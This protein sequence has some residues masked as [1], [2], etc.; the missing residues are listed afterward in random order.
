ASGAAR[1]VTCSVMMLARPSWVSRWPSRAAAEANIPGPRTRTRVRESAVG[2]LNCWFVTAAICAGW[3]AARAT[4]GWAA[5]ALAGWAAMTIVGCAAAGAAGAA[6]GAA[7]ATGRKRFEA[8]A[9]AGAAAIACCG[10]YITGACAGA[11][12]ICGACGWITKLG[13]GTET[14][15]AIVVAIA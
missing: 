7:L 10:T 11:M 12:K 5:T 9:D 14:T 4:A 6:A 2:R 8:G 15:L 3:A 13:P 1:V